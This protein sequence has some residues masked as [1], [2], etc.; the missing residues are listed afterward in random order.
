MKI[1]MISNNEQGF[2]DITRLEKVYAKYSRHSSYKAYF[3]THNPAMVRRM[4]APRVDGFWTAERERF[5]KK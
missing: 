4:P 2:R 3:R 1:S 5:F